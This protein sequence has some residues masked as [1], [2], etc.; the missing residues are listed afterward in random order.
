MN[1]YLLL[2]A[3][4]FYFQTGIA[5]PDI[6]VQ[7]VTG[8]ASYF[9]AEGSRA[10]TVY[11]GLRLSPDGKLRCESG[12]TVKL[13][14]DG[15]IFTLKGSKLFALRELDRL[16]KSGSNAGFMGRFSKFLSGSM[17]E[18]Q[19]DKALEENHR[20]YMEKVKAGIG[21]FSDK[22]FPLQAN[23]LTQGILGATPIVF[24]WS[25]SA[26]GGHYRFQL[27]SKWSGR[28]VATVHTRDS[29]LSLD[30]S[31]LALNEGEAY[32]WWLEDNQT[33]A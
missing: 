1:R 8:K 29:M 15:D 3:S 12:A 7:S 13:L 4:L 2:L 9:E 33:G 18:T 5:Q 20:R 30:L 26:H 32:E 27:K 10:K 23:M 22:P 6:I 24:R 19:N 25:G 21:G 17:K 31:Q 11:P 14:R 16:P 28:A